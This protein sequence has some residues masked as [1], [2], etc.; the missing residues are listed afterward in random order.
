M[1]KGLLCNSFLIANFRFF[2]NL[3]LSHRARA[4]VESELSSK[5]DIVLLNQARL[6]AMLAPEEEYIERPSNLPPIPLKTLDDFYEFEKFL[7]TPVNSDGLVSEVLNSRKLEVYLSL[8]F[9]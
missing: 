7:C 3:G 6:F 8:S 2:L 5:L 9:I 1:N 4:T